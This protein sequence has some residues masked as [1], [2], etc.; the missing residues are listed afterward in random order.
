MV[1]DKLVCEECGWEGLTDDMLSAQ[2]P[3]DATET[4]TGCPVCKQP[5]C[6]VKVCDEPGCWRKVTCGTPVKGG[7]RNTCGV[8]RPKDVV[9]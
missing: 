3:W 8:H 6:L 9:L 5:N 4:I 7:Y 1:T 2:N